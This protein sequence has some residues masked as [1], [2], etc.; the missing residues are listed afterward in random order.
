MDSGQLKEII[1]HKKQSKLPPA[2]LL[3]PIYIHF[4]FSASLNRNLP[5]GQ[6]T[7]GWTRLIQS[8][9]IIQN[10]KSITISQSLPSSQ[11][12]YGHTLT[13]MSAL[14]QL[15]LQLFTTEQFYPSFPKL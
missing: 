14:T 12:Y 3:L 2:P 4:I 9:Q 1:Q 6:V 8:I 5:P 15:H 13:F 7:T 10:K 11:F